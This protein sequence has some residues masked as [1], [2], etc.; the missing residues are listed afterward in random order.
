MKRNANMFVVL[1]IEFDAR[2]DRLATAR[3]AIPD[4]LIERVF[5]LGS[6]SEPQ[7]LK[8]AGLGTYREIGSK[9]ANGCREESEKIWE[10]D[11]LR[12]NAP[13]L[14]RLRRDVRPIL[15]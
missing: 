11:L 13:E 8:Q 2:Q 7:A 15:F 1:L 14:D 12:H 10:H 3:D 9:M 6:W 5:V 4:D